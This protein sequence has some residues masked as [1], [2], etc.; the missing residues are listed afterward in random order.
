MSELTM[1]TVTM[2]SAQYLSSTSVRSLLHKKKER[3]MTLF[4]KEIQSDDHVIPLD[5]AVMKS[6]ISYLS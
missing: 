4:K 5:T 3:D 2:Q 6:N 1:E